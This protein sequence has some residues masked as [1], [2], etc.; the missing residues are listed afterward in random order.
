[1]MRR[2]VPITADLVRSNSPEGFL[3][4][5]TAKLE[6]PDG[7]PIRTTPV[8]LACA[9]TC[10]VH[11]IHHNPSAGTRHAMKDD[12]SLRECSAVPNWNFSFNDLLC[13]RIKNSHS[14]DR[15][16]NA[17]QA[18]VNG[19]WPD[20]LRNIPTV[21]VVIDGSLIDSDITEC[22]VH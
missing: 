15:L 2:A 5:L 19:K 16:R 8:S 7:W 4:T 21:A 14:S 11:E 13:I 22:V 10:G 6:T 18:F 1:M 17:D 20:A 3:V 12:V 9:E